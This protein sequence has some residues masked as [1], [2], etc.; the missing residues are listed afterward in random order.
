MQIISEDILKTKKQFFECVNDYIWHKNS[1]FIWSFI[2]FW[3]STHPMHYTFCTEIDGKMKEMTE[4]LYLLSKNLIDLGDGAD[5]KFITFNALYDLKTF[6]KRKLDMIKWCLYNIHDFTHDETREYALRMI[7]MSL[8][9]YKHVLSHQLYDT[10]IEEFYDKLLNDKNFDSPRYYYTIGYGQ[11]IT[12]LLTY[13]KFC[14]FVFQTDSKFCLLNEKDEILLPF[15]NSI[16][17]YLRGDSHRQLSEQ[18]NN[19]INEIYKDGSLNN[20]F[21]TVETKL[22]H[23][24]NSQTIDIWNNLLKYATINF[25]LSNSLVTKILQSDIINQDQAFILLCLNTWFSILNSKTINNEIFHQIIDQYNIVNKLNNFLLTDYDMTF[26]HDI[27]SLFSL[28]I[29]SIL[30]ERKDLIEFFFNSAVLLFIKPILFEKMADKSLPL[31]NFIKTSIN[32]LDIDY[33]IK[34]IQ[35]IFEREYSNNSQNEL[36]QNLS[37][38]H[39]CFFLICIFLCQNNN[40]SLDLIF[41]QTGCVSSQ[42]NL[43][44]T[45]QSL[46]FLKDFYKYTTYPCLLQIEIINFFG[47]YIK[48]AELLKEH[49][50]ALFD[51]LKYFIENNNKVNF[52]Q[53]V[54][55]M[56]F[57]CEESIVQWINS[58]VQSIQNDDDSYQ[59]IVSALEFFIHKTGNELPNLVE[60]I[61]TLIIN[62]ISS[63]NSDLIHLASYFLKKYSQ[64]INIDTQKAIL[65]LMNNMML[66]PSL[67]PVT[68]F[69]NPK[70][71]PHHQKILISFLK[72]I[73]SIGACIPPDQSITMILRFKDHVP[74]S[75]YPSIAL[76][77]AKNG[78]ISYIKDALS[79]IKDEN[80]KINDAIIQNIAQS[81]EPNELDEN[82][83]HDFSNLVNFIV[84]YS[85]DLYQRSSQG[86]DQQSFQF[87][88][89]SHHMQVFKRNSSY[90]ESISTFL[91]NLMQKM[92]FQD[93]EIIA[94]VNQLLLNYMSIT[95]LP[96]NTFNSILHFLNKNHVSVLVNKTVEVLR[97]YYLYAYETIQYIISYHF[98]ILK[99]NQDFISS[100]ELLNDSDFPFPEYTHF[101]KTRKKTNINDFL[102]KTLNMNNL[103]K[104]EKKKHPKW[105]F[106]E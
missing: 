10:I 48:P 55:Q 22:K 26:H 29:Q 70:S 15:L 42:Q 20:I 68:F 66:D 47:N 98:K 41:Q 102:T 11:F 14:N 9:Y 59:R 84:C 91:I 104:K 12:F 7:T 79:F 89:N 40:A 56:I 33:I 5:A 46:S 45:L 34:I 18:W 82:Q 53:E 87:D 61:D 103:N 80:S 8:Y 64:S 37:I 99:E 105:K 51:I 13:P 30:D 81:I 57:K 54:K 71:F 100:L 73:I 92:K 25:T 90:E 85:L 86:I 31:I 16:S 1:V 3:Q 106:D 63:F 21:A 39:N 94:K 17:E 74:E 58:L 49:I 28:L 4:E 6:E 2:Y 101:L 76:F 95:T 67:F 43:S 36:Q 97:S 72:I 19:L 77:I 24:Y 62:Y 52:S 38:L 83:A 69:E 60:D 88:N 78:Q 32:L 96:S 50:L 65:E 35:N 27:V 75:Y 93:V 23:N 44:M